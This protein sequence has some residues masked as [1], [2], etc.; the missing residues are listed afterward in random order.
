M[1]TIIWTDVDGREHYERC[2]TKEEL[3]DLVSL[4]NLM[5]DEDTLV[6]PPEADDLAMSV[7]WIDFS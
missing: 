7:P 1:W 5:D 3:F 4:N 2:E 6:F